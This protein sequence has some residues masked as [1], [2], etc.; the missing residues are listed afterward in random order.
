MGNRK[1]HPRKS[2]K[3]KATRGYSPEEI[4]AEGVLIRVLE[5][6]NYPGQAIEHYWF[7]DYGWAVAVEKKSDR[8]ITA[9]RDRKIKR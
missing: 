8:L 6:K 3:V 1:S 2:A 9:Y 7:R 4:V 5:N